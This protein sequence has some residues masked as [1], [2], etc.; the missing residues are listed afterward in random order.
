MTPALQVFFDGSCPL[1][2]KEIG[3][4]R[5]ADTAG[6]IHWVDVSAEHASGVLPLARQALLTRFHIQTPDGQL[7]S[8]A[9]GF[10]EMWQQLP[11]WRLLASICS[12]PGVPHTLEIGYCAFLRIRPTIQRY[13]R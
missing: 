1:C 4:Y 6:R 13:F 3:I 8:G 5:N 11:G 12:I 2:Q 9:R 7:I 10:I